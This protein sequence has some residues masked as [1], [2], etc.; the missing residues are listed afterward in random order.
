M[1]N[2]LRISGA[3]IICTIF[4][5]S[6]LRLQLEDDCLVTIEPTTR[7]GAMKHHTA[8]HLLN[9]AVKQVME[10]AY[11]RGCAVNS[12][13]LKLIFNS[14]GQQFATKEIR[15]IEDR[16]NNII[17]SQ[18]AV[19]VRTLNS[20]ELLEQDNVTL[21]PGEIYPYTGL[22]VIEINSDDLQAKLVNPNFRFYMYFCLTRQCN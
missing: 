7:V 19:T 15:T 10:A 21:L 9:A 12:D 8:A 14:F 16:I 5:I 18:T 1:Y 13:S 3:I 20:L 2:K 17:Q 22:R 6:G 4:R 11:Q